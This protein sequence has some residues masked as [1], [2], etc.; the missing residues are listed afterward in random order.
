MRGAKV[1]HAVG[2][3]RYGSC[4][5]LTKGRSRRA[6]RLMSMATDGDGRQVGATRGMPW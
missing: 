5:D 4:V 1:G 6:W 3:D 2:S